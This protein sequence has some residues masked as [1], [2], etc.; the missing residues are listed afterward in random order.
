MDLN[1]LQSISI[2]YDLAMAMAGETRPRPLATVMLQQMMLHTGC[3]CAAVV[4]DDEECGGRIYVAVGNR[5]LRKLE[6]QP[7]PWPSLRLSRDVEEAP[8]GWFT[9]GLHHRPR[10]KR[11]IQLFMNG[12]ASQM[13]LFDYK[14]LLFEKAGQK[15][16]PGG[17]ERVEA[18]T[19]APG[20]IL[21]PP[22]EFHRHG[23][24]GRWVSDQLPHLARHV[25]RLTF[26]MAMQSKTNIHGP[27]SYLMNTGFLTPGRGRY[28]H[29]YAQRTLTPWEAARLQGFPDS[30]DFFPDPKN[31]TTKAKLTKWIGDAVPSPMG[32]AAGL[33]GLLPIFTK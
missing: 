1:Q 3:A 10:A 25:D 29:P 6:G 5:T 2:L 21:R 14:P 19:S 28:I 30:Y 7:A 22:F 33:S 4:L 18:P 9:G 16:D 23:E 27:A 8:D 26:L 32:F 13:D 15:F 12:G 31:P 24:C 17:G 11:V 20:N